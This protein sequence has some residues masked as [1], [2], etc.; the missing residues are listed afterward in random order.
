[1]DGGSL[2]CPAGAGHG[3]HRCGAMLC[4]MFNM[5]QR[6][7]F[8]LSKTVVRELVRGYI[9]RYTHNGETTQRHRSEPGSTVGVSVHVCAPRE[10]GGVAV[11]RAWNRRR[12]G[13]PSQCLSSAKSLCTT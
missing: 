4:W 2:R 12:S 1:M 5:A 3:C 6:H 11:G 9:V 7:V 10:C 8:S 13:L